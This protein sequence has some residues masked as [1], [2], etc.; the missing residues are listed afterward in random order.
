MSYYS[1]LVIYDDDYS[2]N[3]YCPLITP[4]LLTFQENVIMSGIQKCY[5]YSISV[6]LTKI[7]VI[8]YFQTPVCAFHKSIFS[9]VK[10]QTGGK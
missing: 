3:K 7:N 2:D 1:H 8:S 6:M 4:K 10:Q 9:Y 5:M